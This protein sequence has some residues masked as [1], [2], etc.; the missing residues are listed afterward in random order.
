MVLRSQKCQLFRTESTKLARKEAVS[1]QIIASNDDD[2]A[3]NLDF[4]QQQ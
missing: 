3:V 1:S 4:P 2:D